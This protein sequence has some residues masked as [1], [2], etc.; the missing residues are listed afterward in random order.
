MKAVFLDFGTMGAEDLD[1]STL[2][3]VVPNLE[4]FDSTP[5]E[6]V[7]ERIDG[8]EF[9]F[10]NKVRMTAELISNAS[11]LR[12]IGLTATGVDNVDLDA[13][14]KHDVA[15]CNIRSYCTQSVV[16][17]VFAV[18]LNLTHSIRQYDRSARSGAWQK[19]DNFCMLE[20]PIRELSAMT[21]GLVGHGNLGGGVA[22]MARQFGM[23]VMLA[24]RPGTEAAPGDGRF[25]L[26]E[27]LERSDAI[28]LHCPLTDATRGLIGGRELLLMKPGAILI[29]TARG[30]LVDSAALVEAL[31]SG[32]IA[33]AAI[34][35]LPNEPPV[36]GDPLL[37]YE[38]DNLI[39][40]PHI[41][42]GTVEARQKAIDEVAANAEAFLAGDRRNRVV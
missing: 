14:E 28:S 39:L 1:P 26:T 38:G 6:L 40:T 16:E 18:L 9:V 23:T 17:H 10:A 20:F 41:A 33:A 25:A 15:V 29:N 31:R 4:V 21:I 11:D 36:G 30:G 8:V 42:W 27:V 34:D 19:A 2:A 32:T 35:V 37:D 5:P 7:A 24:R 22:R 13:A 3:A 12:F